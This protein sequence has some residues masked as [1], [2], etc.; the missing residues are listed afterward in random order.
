MTPIIDKGIK[1]ALGW[2]TRSGWVFDKESGENVQVKYREIQNVII[3]AQID[4]LDELIRNGHYTSSAKSVDY[5]PLFRLE[6]KV[7]VLK[8]KLLD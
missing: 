8:S 4:C 6:D 7:D 5:V 3:Q 1:R 2:I